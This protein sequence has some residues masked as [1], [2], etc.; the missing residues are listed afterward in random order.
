MISKS[1]SVVAFLACLCA[2]AHAQGQADSLAGEAPIIQALPDA[3]QHPATPVKAF[4]AGQFGGELVATDLLGHALYHPS[5]I[6]IGTIVDVSIAGTK[7][8]SLVVADVSD[9][10]GTDKRGSICLRCAPISEDR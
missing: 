4:V 2:A 9:Y 3:E 7:R 8:Q 1:L 6:E 10:V 5:G